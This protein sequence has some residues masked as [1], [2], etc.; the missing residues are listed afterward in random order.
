MPLQTYEELLKRLIQA[1]EVRGMSLAGLAR[2]LGVAVPTTSSWERQRRRPTEENARRWAG[3][4]GV[5]FPDECDG[6][7]HWA[8]RSKVQLHGTRRGYQWHQRHKTPAC[9]PCLDAQA[10]WSVV[11]RAEKALGIR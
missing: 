6:W 1:R 8:E 10:Q 2:E 9:Q 3:L 7:F 5:P 11:Y 4:L